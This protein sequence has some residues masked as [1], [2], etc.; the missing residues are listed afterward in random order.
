MK[1][2][3][4]PA[5]SGKGFDKKEKVK[6]RGVSREIYRLFISGKGH[7]GRCCFYSE[8]FDLKILFDYGICAGFEGGLNLQQD[9]DRLTGIPAGEIKTREHNFE[10]AFEETASMVLSKN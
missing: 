3:F 1:G 6:T 2:P 5:L 8:L 10:T 4:Q 7:K 9:F